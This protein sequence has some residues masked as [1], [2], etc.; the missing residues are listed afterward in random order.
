MAGVPGAA[1]DAADV[2]LDKS[3]GDVRLL[4]DELGEQFVESAFVI[5]F[6]CRSSSLELPPQNTTHVVRQQRKS[7]YRCIARHGARWRWR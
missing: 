6:L 3:L 5:M 4:H 2:E 1:E 7:L